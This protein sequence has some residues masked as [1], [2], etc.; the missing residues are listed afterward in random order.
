MRNSRLNLEDE[1]G[2]FSLPGVIRDDLRP[3]DPLDGTALQNRT[4]ITR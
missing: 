4:R 1:D 3:F 2:L